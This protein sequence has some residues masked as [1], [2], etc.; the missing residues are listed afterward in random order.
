MYLVASAQSA[1]LE[2][3]FGRIFSDFGRFFDFLDDFSFF[4]SLDTPQGAS[5]VRW[6]DQRHHRKVVRRSKRLESVRIRL[7]VDGIYFLSTL[8]LTNRRPEA[9]GGFAEPSAA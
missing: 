4:F 3:T 9:S 5:G 7:V 6:D 2:C 1:M 8:C